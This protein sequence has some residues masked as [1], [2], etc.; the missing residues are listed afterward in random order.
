MRTEEPKENLK[1]DEVTTQKR[2]YKIL[3]WTDP[4]YAESNLTSCNFG[5]ELSLRLF[6]NSF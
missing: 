1:M 4:A 6:S 2:N 3:N 5:F